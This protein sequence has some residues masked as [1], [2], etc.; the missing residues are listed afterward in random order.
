MPCCIGLL[1][2]FLGCSPSEYVAPRF[3]RADARSWLSVEQNARGL[4][5]RA[6]AVK[7][8]RQVR[9]WRDVD[10]NYYRREFAGALMRPSGTIHG[11]D[12][13]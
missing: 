12:Y 3:P 7:F 10:L 6:R 1:D 2:G 9:Q 11:R 5:R 4:K 13:R 8:R